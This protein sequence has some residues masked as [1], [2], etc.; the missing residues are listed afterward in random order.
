MVPAVNCCGQMA[1]ALVR[2]GLLP[3][4]L[5]MSAPLVIIAPLCS[6]QVLPQLPVGE[7]PLRLRGGCGPRARLDPE[8]GDI[9]VHYPSADMP[10][11]RHRCLRSALHRTRVRKWTGRRIYLSTSYDLTAKER[12]NRYYWNKPIRIGTMKFGSGNESVVRVT[13]DDEVQAWGQWHY[14]GPTAGIYQGLFC[15]YTN[16][17]PYQPLMLLERYANVLFQQCEVRNLG[18]KC[19][20][21][22]TFAQLTMEWCTVGGS[23][24]SRAPPHHKQFQIWR[25][26]LQGAVW[27]S[28][29]NREIIRKFLGS[30]TGAEREKKK[31]KIDLNDLWA[32]GGSRHASDGVSCESG[33][34]LV[35]RHVLFEDTGRAGGMALRCVGHARATLVRCRFQRN[36]IHLAADATASLTLLEC[37]TFFFDETKRDVRGYAGKAT[38]FHARRALRLPG[39]GTSTLEAQEPTVDGHI[40]WREV[41][42]TKRYWTVDAG[43]RYTDPNKK[44]KRVAQR[45][46]RKAAKQRLKL[47]YQELGHAAIPKHEVIRARRRHD[48]TPFT[49][50]L[51][52][53][54]EAYFDAHPSKRAAW[55]RETYGRA[56]Y[57][58]ETLA[59]NA[60]GGH[61]VDI[62][63]VTG[64]EVTGDQ[65]QQVN[66]APEPTTGGVPRR[67]GRGR[68]RGGV[69]SD[70]AGE[71]GKTH[72][73]MQEEEEI[74][75]LAPLRNMAQVH[76]HDVFA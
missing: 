71:K 33:A 53:E 65:Q 28:R 15:M 1:A 74:D 14:A 25:P 60:E 50:A 27:N 26:A 36:L 41:G 66:A 72:D 19:V 55:E 31:W 68:G 9:L 24:G 43:M 62:D 63:P 47:Q 16:Y 21:A 29:S 37:E 70:E 69:G 40:E 35:A 52:P 12:R 7:A 22:R 48:F 59:F 34:W 23:C 64:E 54:Q 11:P 49:N 2:F 10:R 57:A 30:A 3:M 18:G 76:V 58:P 4:V 17:G 32:P 51:T 45:L 20:V 5:T 73:A 56:I 6:V 38:T 67:R 39:N 42:P 46:Q 13:G 61:W 75:D 44:A 8:P